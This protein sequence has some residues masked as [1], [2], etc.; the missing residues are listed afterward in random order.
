[1]GTHPIFESDF[2]CLTEILCRATEQLSAMC[3]PVARTKRRLMGNALA[4]KATSVT[5][6]T[7]ARSIN[8][9]N[10]ARQERSITTGNATTTFS[11]LENVSLVRHL[12]RLRRN[13]KRA[14]ELHYPVHEY[15]CFFRKTNSQCVTLRLS[16]L[17]ENLMSYVHYKLYAYQA[18]YCLTSVSWRYT[19]FTALSR[20][21]VALN[22]RTERA[23][24]RTVQTMSS[25]GA[26]TIHIVYAFVASEFSSL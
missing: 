20:V 12:T 13:C 8:R 3:S 7:W 14:H 1:M 18:V 11:A 4:E 24:I 6:S 22:E 10:R 17:Q 15:A 19:I 25:E 26:A 21:S 9:R 23:R 2:D 16:L 5:S